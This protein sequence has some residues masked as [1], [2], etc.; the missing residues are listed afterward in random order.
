MRTTSLPIGSPSLG[1]YWAEP[2]DR[3]AA[4]AGLKT[5]REIMRQKALQPFVMAER[6]PGP[7]IT[8][9][10]ALAEFAFR[11]CKTDHH[12]VGTCRMGTDATAVV[13]PDLRLRGLEGLR[14]CDSSVMPLIPS[15]NTNAP[16]IMIA[17]K[18][19]DL[20]RGRPPLPPAEVGA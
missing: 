15:C 13:A 7:E 11:T 2:E 5:A 16:T 3:R 10:E 14:V 20:I 1:N 17:E 19:T 8:G 6:L 12:P 4:L 18:A 9:D